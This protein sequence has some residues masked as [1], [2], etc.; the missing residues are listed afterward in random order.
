MAIDCM[1]HRYA[2]A[3]MNPGIRA[4]LRDNRLPG[5]RFDNSE[6]PRLRAASPIPQEINPASVRPRQKVSPAGWG[7]IG[8]VPSFE[9]R[10]ARSGG[11]TS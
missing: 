6:V 7:D 2:I 4:I 5:A 10:I 11:P 9:T 1:V 3:A 8:G